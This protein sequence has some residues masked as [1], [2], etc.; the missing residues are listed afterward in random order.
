M[1][2]DFL[3]ESIYD[4]RAK[5]CINNHSYFIRLAV[6]YLIFEHIISKFAL[7]VSFDV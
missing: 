7:K 3:P 2:P 6:K 1:N 5:V 4:V